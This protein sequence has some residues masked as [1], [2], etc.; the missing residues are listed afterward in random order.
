MASL[1]SDNPRQAEIVFESNSYYNFVAGQISENATKELKEK[2][3]HNLTEAYSRSI[4][5]QFET[6]SS[7]LGDA[8][9]GA[10]RLNTGLSK[11]GTE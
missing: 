7:G 6:L 10:A 8:S 2:L 11:Y 3:S 4:Y 5:S 9:E 1:S